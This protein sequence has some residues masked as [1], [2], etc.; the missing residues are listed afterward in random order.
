MDSWFG[1]RMGFIA[2]GIAV[3][4]FIIPIFVYMFVRRNR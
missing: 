2:S 1:A 3:I 4:V